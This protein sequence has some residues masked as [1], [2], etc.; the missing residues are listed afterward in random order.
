MEARVEMYQRDCGCQ[1]GAAGGRGL[2]GGSNVRCVFAAF[3]VPLLVRGVVV[4]RTLAVPSRAGLRSRARHTLSEKHYQI[5]STKKAREQHTCRAAYT[6]L[7]VS[8]RA[9]SFGR[10]SSGAS[11]AIRPGAARKD[12]LRCHTAPVSVSWSSACAPS[13]Y[14][15]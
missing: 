4:P 15:R 2:A 11:A 6:E 3:G 14:E 12:A 13:G 7:S 10:S 5:R 8:M 1:A 9:P